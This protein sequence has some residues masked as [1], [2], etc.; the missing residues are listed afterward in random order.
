MLE[1][2][3]IAAAFLAEGG[4]SRAIS[5]ERV[6]NRA[7]ERDALENSVVTRIS[8]STR[9]W[10][11]R[12]RFPRI[13]GMI[14]IGLLLC[15]TRLA[16]VAAAQAAS[17]PAS[18]AGTIGIADSPPSTPDVGLEKL[19]RLPDSYKAHSASKRGV[20][21]EEWQ[22][23]FQKI[24]DDRSEAEGALGKAQIELDGMAKGKSDWSMSAIGGASSETSPVSYRLRQEIRRQNSA[25]EQADRQIRDLG[26]EADL[27]GV[28]QDWRD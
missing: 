3:R 28:P 1:L 8:R 22:S 21:K 23:R 25:I 11:V 24:R 13:A 7:E 6:R 26:I 10:G 19:L 18:E 14:A 12:R 20:G 4:G 15:S 2:A 16:G 9:R 5:G 27:A 17:D